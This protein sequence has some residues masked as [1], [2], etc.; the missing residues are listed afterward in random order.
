[1]KSLV[2]QV[3]TGTMSSSTTASACLPSLN[4]YCASEYNELK[5]RQTS[6]SSSTPS[7]TSSSLSSLILDFKRKQSQPHPYTT[8]LASQPH[9]PMSSPLIRVVL[10]AWDTHEWNNSSAAL[11]NWLNARWAKTGCQVSEETVC[12]TLRTNGR[13]AKMGVTDPLDGAFVR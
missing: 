1:M 13:D 4:L 10:E 11:T 3:H 5:G 8:S 9:E 7:S 6:E 2:L 12:F